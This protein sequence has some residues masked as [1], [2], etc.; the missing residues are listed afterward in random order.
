MHPA[1]PISFVALAALAL[2]C[3]TLL[4]PANPAFATPPS[5]PLDFTVRAIQAPRPGVPVDFIVEVTP[6]AACE[7][8]V[9]RVVLPAD[10]GLTRGDTL[11]SVPAPA[12]GSTGRLDYSV[13]IPPGL[14]RRIYVRATMETPDG[15]RYT[16]G[17]NLVLLAGPS[18]EPVPA[19]RVGPDGRGGEVVEYDGAPAASHR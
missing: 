15:H 14:T 3:A 16:R 8:L 7:R 6:R 19:R 18:R 9:V 12:V 5:P 4:P 2:L 11:R 13:R 1:R 17:E 10:C